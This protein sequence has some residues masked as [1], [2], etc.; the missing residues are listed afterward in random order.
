MTRPFRCPGLVD[1]PQQANE[2]DGVNSSA[3]PGVE[4][5][6]LHN[7]QHQNT[8]R[9]KEM[10]RRARLFIWVF[11]SMTVVT[12]MACADEVVLDN[13]D[14]ITGKLVR[15]KEGKLIFKTDYAG[16]ITIQAKRVSRLATDIN[17]W[18]PHFSM[19]ESARPRFSPDMSPLAMSI[20]R[21]R[22]LRR[23]SIPRK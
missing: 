4:G 9:E 2:V 22:N 20:P 10:R 16:E 23:I 3:M 1:D 18:R 11:F 17:P 8:F 5:I 7:R 13:G 14:G 15:L 19:L 21:L 6:R 12:H